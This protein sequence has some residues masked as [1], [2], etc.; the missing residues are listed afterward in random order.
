MDSNDSTAASSV[1]IKPS[2]LLARA[3]ILQQ[4][5]NTLYMCVCVN[6]PAANRIQNTVQGSFLY[7]CASLPTLV[8]LDLP[9]DTTFQTLGH[10]TTSPLPV[11]SSPEDNIKLKYSLTKRRKIVYLTELQ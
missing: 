7:T 2:S 5:F 4:S 9:A 1:G 10:Q 6:M 3:V 8:H 11:T